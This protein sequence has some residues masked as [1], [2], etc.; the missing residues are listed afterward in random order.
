MAYFNNNANFYPTSSASGEPYEYP[1]LGQRLVTEGPDIQAHHALANRW[2][3][4]EQPG[5]MVGEPT[6]PQ[7]TANGKCRCNLFVGWCLTRESPESVVSATSYMTQVDGY[8]QLS[9]SGYQWPA[10]GLQAGSHHSD[11]LRRDHSFAS[12]ATLETS[13]RSRIVP[14]SYWGDNQ[15]ESLNSRF[16]EVSAR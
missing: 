3:M 2:N 13:T 4:T 5:P 11:F 1:F 8:S 16:H 10:V 7:V 15:S 9:Y 14:L 6:S 12:I